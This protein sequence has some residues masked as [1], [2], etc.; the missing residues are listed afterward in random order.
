MVSYPMTFDVDYKAALDRLQENPDDKAAQ[1][2]LFQTMQKS[3]EL[4]FLYKHFNRHRDREDVMEEIVTDIYERWQRHGFRDI[5]NPAGYVF[6]AATNQVKHYF[7]QRGARERQFRSRESFSED[8]DQYRSSKEENSIPDPHSQLR[9]VDKKILE[10]LE[11]GSLADVA[12]TPDE[13]ELLYTVLDR[14][15]RKDVTSTHRH[16]PYVREMLESLYLLAPRRS[17]HQWSTDMSVPEGTIKRRMNESRIKL[18]NEI[19]ELQHGKPGISELCDDLLKK[20]RRLDDAQFH[21]SS[22]HTPPR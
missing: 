13:K 7:S 18:L 15:H 2:E 16:T 14:L 1:A 11:G 17:V 12:Y 21:R 4:A 19:K 5:D 8:D 22:A 10:M 20:L 3:C 6:T 9:E